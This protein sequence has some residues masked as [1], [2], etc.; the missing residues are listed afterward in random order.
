[1]EQAKTSQLRLKLGAALER[2]W[3][4]TNPTAGQH[5]P[6]PATGAKRGLPQL[7]FS[8]APQPVVSCG[9]PAGDN[10][11][12]TQQPSAETIIPPA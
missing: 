1:M 4:L 5:K 7:Q 10:L 11:S 2:L 3:K 12:S 8:N 6:R 9:V